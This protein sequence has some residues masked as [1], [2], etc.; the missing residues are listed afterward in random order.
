MDETIAAIDRDIAARRERGDQL[1][2][3]AAGTPMG[4]YLRRFW[5]PVAIASE[6]DAWPLKNVRLLGES[7]ALFRMDDGALGLVADRCPHRG[8]SLACGMTDGPLLRCAYHG[9]AFAADG[10]CVDTPAEAATSTLKIRA[11]IRGY[12]VEQLG[13]LIWAYL[14]PLPAPLLPRYEQLVRSDLEKTIGFTDL[15][16]HWL[17]V[18]ENNLDPKHVEYLHMR[19]MNWVRKR[20]GEP[21]VHVR[22]HAKIDFEVFE[23]GILKKRLWEGD[24]EDSDEWRTGHPLFFPGN[25]LVAMTARHVELQ[26]RVPVDE[27]NT[28]IYWYQAK[29]LEPGQTAPAKI[30][31]VGNPWK[32]ED[33]AYRPESIQGQ[34]MMMFVSMGDVD[35]RN[36]H[37]GESD[38]G[39]ALYRRILLEECERVARGEDP[40]GV[41]RDPAKNEPFIRLPHERTFGFALS[42]VQN[43]ATQINPSREA[44]I[45]AR[46]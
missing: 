36:E 1:S 32:T 28:A 13:G 46:P 38:R 3:I 39:V 41:V 18:A 42:E 15:P 17:R 34:D 35:I 24:S 14:G 16:C 9:W 5:Y 33:G 12:K 11:G 19:F 27:K 20:R 21:P 44:V 37:L 22:R 25:N 30:P 4:E 31:V 43:N 29:E 8:A 6:L 23:Y 26:F 10:T 45:P 2:G 7:L 40:R